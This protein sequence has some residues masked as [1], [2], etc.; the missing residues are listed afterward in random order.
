MAD[1]LEKLRITEL[2]WF[3]I[4]T[5]FRIAFLSDESPVKNILRILY[6]LFL[7]ATGLLYGYLYNVILTKSQMPG[8]DAKVKV[9][10]I[11]TSLFVI[12][13]R[14]YFPT[15]STP[16]N[17]IS[18]IYPVRKV[19]K[20][21]VNISSDLVTSVTIFFAG[22]I[23]PFTIVASHYSITDLLLL[24]IIMLSAILFDRGIRMMMEYGVKNDKLLL[25]G[26]VII[27]VGFIAFLTQ[28]YWFYNQSS[29]YIWGVALLLLMVC[30]EYSFWVDLSMERKAQK[31]KVRKV[32]MKEMSLQKVFR[33]IYLRDKKFRRLAL[34]LLVKGLFLFEIFQNSYHQ[35]HLMVMTAFFAA[36][37]TSPALIFSYISNNF[38]GHFREMWFA[39]RVYSNDS[40]ELFNLYLQSLLLPVSLDFV[41][42]VILLGVAVYYHILT[43]VWVLCY[44]AQL[45]LF[46]Y[47]GFVISIL[48]PIKIT[49]SMGSSFKRTTSQLYSS[50]MLLV[51]AISGGIMV[52]HWYWAFLAVIPIAAFIHIKLMSFYENNRH[53]IYQILF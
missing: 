48:K 46:V 38:F 10:V 18:R 34:T 1:G 2:L 28:L 43:P 16:S 20:T 11:L 36:I 3:T 24:V 47:M 29:V 5:K 52:M 19:H 7:A 41:L 15:F 21:I 42:S 23:I 39:N 32:S 33:H 35:S 27:L 12:I 51:V 13:I 40:N 37:L 49:E 44:F 53:K 9:V 26:T 6:F 45:I 14:N 4:K 25:V 8:I 31:H 30:F 50:L 17:I 22:F